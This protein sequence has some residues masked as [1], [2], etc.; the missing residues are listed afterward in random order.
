MGGDS[1][2][3]TGPLPAWLGG[4]ARAA[5]RVYLG[6]VS[7][8][9][10]AWD[11]G[12]GV[13][14]LDRPVIS[15]GNLSVGGTGKTPV[16]ATI[17]GWLLDDGRTPAIAMRGYKAKG[18]VSDEASE[19]ASLFG[20]R[21]PVVA[22]PDRLEG[23]L[24]LFA[25][26]GDG[27]D[28]VVLDDGFQHR[29]V[30]RGLDIV[31][32]DASRDPFDDACLPAGWLR[33]PVGSL[34]RAD[35]VVLTHAEMVGSSELMSLRK[36]VARVTEARVAVAAHRWVSLDVLA[37]GGGEE[38]PVA[39][40]MDKRVYAACAI[41]NP[42]GFLD[43]ARCAAGGHL[44][45]EMVLRDHH[46]FDG[47]AVEGLIEAAAG[48]DVLVVTG[49]DWAKLSSVDAGRW[50]CP[51]ARPRLSI[52]FVEGEAMLRELVLGSVAEDEMRGDAGASFTD[53]S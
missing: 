28:C 16:V 27:V 14:T 49:K 30:A 25:E 4:V 23:L 26:V 31:L 21:V 8:K 42:S 33:E 48:S 29:R 12:R 22:Q 53:R 32:I 35:V 18:G 50:P 38:R 51:V 52:G 34:S 9:N 5:S 46:P 11:L 10:R 3:T 24:R 39:W 13:V 2:A 47:G 44:S 41:G 36:A 1:R 6:V 19:Y 17:V 7:R 40:L 20:A 43:R 45:G 37:D 15:V